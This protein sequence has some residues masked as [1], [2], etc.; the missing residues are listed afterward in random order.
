[1]IDSTFD[2]IKL[3]IINSLFTFNSTNLSNTKIVLIFLIYSIYSYKYF[4][5]NYIKGKIDRKNHVYI[6]GKRHLNCS[7]GFS[8]YDELYTKFELNNDGN[9]QIKE[10]ETVSPE[11]IDLITKANTAI[12]NC[13]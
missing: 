12:S 3:Q 11:M 5:F 7:R 10:G 1:M 8:R 13:V 2:I 6:E 4:I 9:L